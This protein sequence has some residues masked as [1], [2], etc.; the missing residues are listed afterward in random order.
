MAS[1]SI[2]S[3]SLYMHIYDMIIGCFQFFFVPI[4]I[5][6]ISQVIVIVEMWENSQ[7]EC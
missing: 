5:T 1:A 2:M 3:S 7:V 4:L 6:D